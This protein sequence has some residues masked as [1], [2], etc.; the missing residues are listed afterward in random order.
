MRISSGEAAA[1][2]SASDSAIRPASR[3]VKVERSAP[4]TSPSTL[5]RWR[6]DETRTR[7]AARI[8]SSVI[9]TARWREPSAPSASAITCARGPI[10]DPA[11][12]R[13]PALP[14][15]TWSRIAGGRYQPDHVSSS[16]APSADRF[17]LPVHTTSTV[18]AS[19]AAPAASRRRPRERCTPS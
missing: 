5:S 19:P 11:G 7:S 13:R 3:I 14:I 1:G 8:A 15:R 17:T 4:G 2:R 16:T 9:C 10:D 6:A 18:N 12:A